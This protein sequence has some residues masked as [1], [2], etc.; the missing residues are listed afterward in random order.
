MKRF[1]HVVVRM[2]PEDR[3]GGVGGSSTAASGVEAL[4]EHLSER[5]EQFSEAFFHDSHPKHRLLLWRTA[6]PRKVHLHT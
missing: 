2:E 1:V 6:I 4:C 5:L 3:G